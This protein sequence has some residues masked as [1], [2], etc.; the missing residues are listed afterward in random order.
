MKKRKMTQTLKSGKMI[1][2]KGFFLLIGKWSEHRIR[3]RL[4]KGA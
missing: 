1:V 2:N 4:S 3:T